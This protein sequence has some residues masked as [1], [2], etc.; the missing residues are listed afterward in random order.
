MVTIIQNT[1]SLGDDVLFE[2]R[3]PEFDR[4]VQVL[5]CTQKG[6]WGEKGR[7]KRGGG[8]G[9]LCLPG[10]AFKRDAINKD[11]HIYRAILNTMPKHHP[12]R[13]TR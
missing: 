11:A 8:G 5:R 3:S 12:A 10:L 4:V 2:L 6:W 13:F 1:L 7:G 9:S